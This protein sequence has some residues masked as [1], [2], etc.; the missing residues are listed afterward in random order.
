MFKLITTCPHIASASHGACCTSSL[1]RISDSVQT[2]FQD[3][4]AEVIKGEAII[5]EIRLRK[6]LKDVTQAFSE[7]T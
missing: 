1:Q 2:I 5:E 4:C 3:R 7:K 6:L